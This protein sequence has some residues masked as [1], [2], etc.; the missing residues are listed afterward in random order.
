[1]REV[2]EAIRREYEGSDLQESATGLYF[3]VAPQEAVRPYVTF[4]P[5]VG[6]SDHSMS[7]VEERMTVQFSIWSAEDSA[8]EACELFEQLRYLYD[9]CALAIGLHDTIRMQRVNYNLLADPDGGWHYQCDY[10]IQFQEA[11]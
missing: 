7:D 4:F 3:V 9:E 8:V 10:L 2:F 6:V 1:M 11:R 5:V